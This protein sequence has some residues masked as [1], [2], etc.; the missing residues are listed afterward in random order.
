MG[1]IRFTLHVAEY[2]TRPAMEK[3]RVALSGH[4]SGH[5]PILNTKIQ[6]SDLAV[7]G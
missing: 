3:A 1:R 4:N 2:S 6:I 5:S 7:S